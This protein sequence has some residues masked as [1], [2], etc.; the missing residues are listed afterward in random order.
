MDVTE[1]ERKIEI[2]LEG[3]DVK[4]GSV[5]GWDDAGWPIIVSERERNTHDVM[6]LIEWHEKYGQGNERPAGA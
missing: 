5:V 2:M 3:T 6:L 1:I 4:N